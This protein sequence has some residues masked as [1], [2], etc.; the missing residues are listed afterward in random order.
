MSIVMHPLTA[1]AGSPVYTADDYRRMVNPFMFPSDGTA[2]DCV[3]GVRAGSPSPLCTIDGLTV[4]V[5]P[6]CGVVS[7]WVN[8][9]AYTYA[10]TKE[11]AVK[12]PNSTY[13][14][15]IAI[16]VEDPGTSH[17]SVPRGVVKV[18]PSSTDDATIPGLVLAQVKAGVV[19]DVFPILRDGTVVEAP[20]VDRLPKTAVLE[21][22]SAVV[23]STGRK[24]VMRSGKW[25][26]A[27][28]VQ[29]ETIGGGEV[30]VIYGQSSC[31]VQV[32]GV[33][34]G[35]GSWD[36][37]VCN[38]KVREG[39][40]PFVELSASLLVEN[41]GSNTGLV[42]VGTDGTIVIKNMGAAGSVSPRRGNISWPVA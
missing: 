30:D 10:V 20:T 41:G 35:A 27:V 29:K 5:K 25:Q 12:V 37:V 21:G 31:C 7:P 38:W 16:T 8:G 15:K 19:S 26:N 42:V 28:E 23:T 11:E 4:T 17:G 39:W 36:T 24:Y 33:A 13:N 34:I 40:R 18:Y 1:M 32:N 9:G 22:Q 6:H 14:Y 2:F 3:A